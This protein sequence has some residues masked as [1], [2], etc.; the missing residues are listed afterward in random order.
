MEVWLSTADASP[1][2]LVTVDPLRNVSTYDISN[3]KRVDS[4]KVSDF[5]LVPEK[6][7]DVIDMR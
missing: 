6:G 5:V 2:R 1:M 7:V 4:V 3:L